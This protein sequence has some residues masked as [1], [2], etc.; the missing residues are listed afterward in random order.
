[1]SC[2]HPGWPDLKV[3]SETHVVR[4][5]KRAALGA[6]ISDIPKMIWAIN[7]ALQTSRRSLSEAGILHQPCHC[8]ALSSALTKVTMHSVRWQQVHAC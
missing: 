1:M 5:N 2:R 3:V 7:G 8:Y 4:V 6:C